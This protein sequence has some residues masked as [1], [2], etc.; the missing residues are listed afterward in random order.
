MCSVLGLSRDGDV[1]AVVLLACEDNRSVDKRVEGVVLT[2]TYTYTWVVLRAT[3]T[4]DDVTSLSVL[5]AEELNTKS[6]AF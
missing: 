2:D 5:T 4:Y 3:L 1:R 6:F